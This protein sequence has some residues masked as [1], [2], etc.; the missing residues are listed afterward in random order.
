EQRTPRQAGRNGGVVGV[1]AAR[2]RAQSVLQHQRS[3]R[4]EESELHEIAARESSLRPRLQDL[5]TV[6]TSVLGFPHSS[7]RR[8]PWK[9]HSRLS[10]PLRSGT[11]RGQRL[12]SRTS[13][14]CRN[15]AD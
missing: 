11:A 15:S 1:C 14:P 9:V 7:S 4:R 3:A 12:T 6:S 13:V 8:V 2:E 10:L 5:R